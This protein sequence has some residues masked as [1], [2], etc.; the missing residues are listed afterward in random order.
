MNDPVFGLSNQN[1]IDV[2]EK[3]VLNSGGLIIKTG[4]SAVAKTVN[5]VYYFVAGKMY[6]LAAGDMTAL[7]GTITDGYYNV[8][9]F[10]IDSDGN[11]ST[12]MGTEA[13]AVEDVVFPSTPSD[14]A[15]IGFV[16]VYTSGAEFVG[17]TTALDD[18]N[19]TDVYIDADQPMRFI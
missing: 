19:V 10:A 11:I 8:Y 3:H 6:K 2:L 15:V 12:N 17:G 13:L 1:L 9:V 4:S 18:G 16:L 14:E 5:D 7:S